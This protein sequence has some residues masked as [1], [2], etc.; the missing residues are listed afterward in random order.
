MNIVNMISINKTAGN[1]E[2]TVSPK[3]YAC[4]HCMCAKGA[5]LKMQTQSS[6]ES[7]VKWSVLLTTF[8][9]VITKSLLLHFMI[10]LHN[11]I[12]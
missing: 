12:E 6:L 2:V 9:F 1:S 8:F 7:T 3:L 5:G 4:K 10:N 11:R